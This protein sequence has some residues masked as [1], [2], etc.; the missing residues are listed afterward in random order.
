MYI[1]HSRRDPQPSGRTV[2][3]TPLPS[4]VYIS[5]PPP[6][7]KNFVN[8]YD[9]STLL[10]E[11]IVSLEDL[12]DVT[13]IIV[14]VI[15][16]FPGNLVTVT[17]GSPSRGGDVTVYVYDTNQPSL[18]TPLILFLCLFLSLQ[19]FQLYFIP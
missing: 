14:N 3:R 13:V 10:R 12:A 16:F 17:T 15:T 5:A 1:V 8:N 9:V 6:T 18:P 19:P 11:V 4:T 2:A 7:P